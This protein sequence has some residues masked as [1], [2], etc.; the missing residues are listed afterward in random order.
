M[1]DVS[2]ALSLA[3]QG[4]H[5]FPIR[6]LTKLPAIE[7]FPTR[8]TRD[9]ERIQR[10]A[11]RFPGC[12]WGISTSAY[13]DSDALVVVDVDGAGH[14]KNGPGELVRL[15][16]DGKDFP[17]TCEHVTP[18]GGRH[19]IYRVPAAL[20]QGVD[21][22][23][24]GLDIRSKGGYVVA[25][26]SRV[27]AGEYFTDRPSAPTAAPQ[28]LVDACGPARTR[29]ANREA[30][31]GIDPV[32]AEQRV[33][34]Y[35]KT[36]ERSVKG[37]GGDQCAY[38]VAAR[39]MALGAT[40]A[41]TLDLM[42]SEHWDEGCG[43]SPDRLAEKVRH[44]TKYMQDAPGAEAPEAQFDPIDEA[45]TPVA[46][47]KGHPFDELNKQ[48]AV[49]LNDGDALVYRQ[50]DLPGGQVKY[51]PMRKGAFELV[52]KDRRL[53]F[54][55]ASKPLAEAWLG[56]P[57]RRFYRN[58]V[59]F[60][61]EQRV[62]EGVLN[63][64]GGFAVRPT[65]GDWSIFRELVRDVVCGGDAVADA[66]VMG[67]LAH[68]VQQPYE[69]AGVALVLRG[70]QGTGK[71]TFGETIGSIF[72]EHFVHIYSRQQLTG[73]FNKHL[74]CKVM[75][76]ADEAF[77]AG[78]RQDAP[79]LKALLTQGTM[80]MEAK[81]VDVVKVRNCAH[82]VMASN[83][84]W[85]VPASEDQRRF[86]VLDVSDCRRNDRTFFARLRAQMAAGG[87]AGMLHDLLA[88]DL[89]GFN[90]GQFPETAAGLDQKLASLEGPLRWLHGALSNGW[91]AGTEWADGP[92]QLAKET[93][94]NDYTLQSRVDREYRPVHNA[95][96]WKK[97]REIFGAALGTAKLRVGGE[98][99]YATVLPPLEDA[100][101]MFERF[102]GG[103]PITWDAG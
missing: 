80:L 43:W 4:F 68:M 70:G 83:D 24:K 101:K 71:S 89:A 12:N 86:C 47:A 81:G 69:P 20:R 7:A 3:R 99:Q 94:Y 52:L 74:A 103:V 42:L 67:W 29:S 16:M 46:G 82:V 73:N 65:P 77:F 96:F 79:V 93:A 53:Q 35:L 28:W 9:P 59:D 27:E 32:R 48:F 51:T 87:L 13:G 62:S 22:L 21:V 19:I 75:V 44:A 40:Q 34:E 45:D 2:E 8:A 66:Y 85:V 14:G 18:S 26:G 54:D 98:R 100:R 33:I 15:E 6:P 49:V 10:W 55:G 61:P 36:A 50:Q 102:L 17:L 25:P 58:G 92:V 91:V 38:R 30:L 78:N 37:A 95:L 23:A 5:L 31:P 56:S 11:D 39:C 63:L 76:L 90:I 64:W 88:Y 60:A 41:Q 72:G 1:T 57:S 84:E 97:L